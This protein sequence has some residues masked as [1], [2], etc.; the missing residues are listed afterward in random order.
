MLLAH[1]FGVPVE[2]VAIPWVGGA[3]ASVLIA[4]ASGIR[5][6]LFKQRPR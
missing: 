4:L 3:G 1:I 5:T 2:E 6:I